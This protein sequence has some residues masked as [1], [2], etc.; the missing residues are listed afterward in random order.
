MSSMA[1]FSPEY[2]AEDRGGP[3]LSLCIAF[4]VLE[5]VF[6]GLFITSR[7]MSNTATE[8]DAYLIV[9]GLPFCLAELTIVMCK[10]LP[11]FLL[12]KV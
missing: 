6:V 8:I 4:I 2:L 11:Y 12:L 7:I 5:I 9:L 10:H 3:L 1:Q